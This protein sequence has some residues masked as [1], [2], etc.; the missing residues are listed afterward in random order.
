MRVIILSFLFAHLALAQEIQFGVQSA[1]LGG[2]QALVQENA[3]TVFLNPALLL[4]AS[5]WSIWMTYFR[6]FRLPDLNAQGLAGHYAAA[7]FAFGAAFA[8]WG[9]S[10]YQERLLRMA[11]AFRAGDRLDLGVTFQQRAVSISRYGRVAQ[12][13][14]DVGAVI[15]PNSRVQFGILWRQAF[16]FRSSSLQ[17]PPRREIITGIRIA[18]PAKLQIVSEISRAAAFE[19]T[20]RFAAEFQPIPRLQLSAGSGFN[21]P[22][23]FAFG[24][25]IDFATIR[26]QYALTDHAVLPLTHRIALLLRGN[27]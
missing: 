19:P 18:L 23:T 8:Q 16:F 9:N 15:R 12:W 17:E 14:G 2:Q 1:A 5:R 10:L 26:I 11:L 22:E 13:S 4:T 6:P 21:T 3:G 24:M 20:W 7:G 25:A 27:P